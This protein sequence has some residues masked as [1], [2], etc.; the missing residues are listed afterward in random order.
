MILYLNDLKNSAKKF[1]D[2]IKTF[3][4]V[5]GEKINLYRDKG[6]IVSARC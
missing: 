2:T 5:A 4:K 1:L 3:S 6:K